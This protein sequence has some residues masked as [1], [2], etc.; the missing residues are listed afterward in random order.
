MVIFA[1]IRVRIATENIELLDFKVRIQQD[2]VDEFSNGGHGSANVE[3]NAFGQMD[4]WLEE[5]SW[6]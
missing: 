4:R 1:G 2:E 3:S 6:Q 5:S